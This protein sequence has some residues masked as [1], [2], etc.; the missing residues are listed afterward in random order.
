MTGVAL[1]IIVEAASSPHNKFDFKSH[2]SRFSGVRYR[3][4]AFQGGAGQR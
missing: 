3:S 4:S 1:K 2:I